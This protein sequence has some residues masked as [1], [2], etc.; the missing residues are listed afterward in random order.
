MRI[1]KKIEERIEI[2]CSNE[3]GKYDMVLY[4]ICQDIHQEKK[5]KKKQLMHICMVSDLKKY[6]FVVLM[7]LCRT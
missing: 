6:D 1:N 2:I 4:K 5:L 3:D 7:N